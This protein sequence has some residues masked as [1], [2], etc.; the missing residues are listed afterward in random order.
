MGG[1]GSES[2]VNVNSL[3]CL[4]TNNSNTYGSD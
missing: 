2:D 4:V 1:H 3:I